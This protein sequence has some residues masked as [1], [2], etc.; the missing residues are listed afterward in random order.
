MFIAIGLRIK[1]EISTC[2]GQPRSNATRR[3]ISLAEPLPVMQV[4][5]ATVLKCEYA[6][7]PP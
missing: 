4:S 5:L 3:P 6:L 1:A 2:F 7:D